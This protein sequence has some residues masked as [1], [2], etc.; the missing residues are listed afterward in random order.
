MVKT[1]LSLPEDLW[2]AA[3]IRAIDERAEL[4]AVV[5]RAL[6]LYLKIKPRKEDER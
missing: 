1:S 2:R 5:A 4:Q 3:K 6:D